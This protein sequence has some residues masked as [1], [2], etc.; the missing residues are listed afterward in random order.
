MPRH[1][2]PFPRSYWV[3]PGKLLAG[4]Y[5]G[6]EEAETAKQKLS[7][8]VQ[9]RIRHVINLME[10]H[11]VNWSGSDFISYEGQMRAIAGEMGFDVTVDRMPI[12]D[13]GVPSEKEMRRILDRIDECIKAKKPVY[14][15]CWGGR[16]RTGTVAG[17]YL[18]RH[19]Y[20]SGNNLIELLKELR[21]NTADSNRASPETPTQLDMVF[22]WVKGG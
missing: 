18:A 12:K 13:M 2:I 16:G 17:C 21:K 14:I 9:H 4:C 3:I 7:S 10:P 11:E 1:S 15:H 8:L 19:G 6:A 20:A 22:S 5:P